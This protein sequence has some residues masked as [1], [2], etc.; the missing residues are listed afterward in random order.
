MVK[1]ITQEDLQEK[2]SVIEIEVDNLEKA[3]Q[4][5]TDGG[6][7]ITREMAEKSTLEDYYFRL[8]GGEK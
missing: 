8:V 7:K 5:L 2:K 3:R 4:L 6:V 1:E